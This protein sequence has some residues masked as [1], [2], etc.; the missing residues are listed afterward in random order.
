M[1]TPENP[2]EEAE[3]KD[4][5]VVG[6]GKTRKEIEELWTK[7]FADVVSPLIGAAY[8]YGGHDLGASCVQLLGLG[9]E[10]HTLP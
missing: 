5:P 7:M 6:G 2:L 9:P 8:F 4:E 3:T 10:W 1:V